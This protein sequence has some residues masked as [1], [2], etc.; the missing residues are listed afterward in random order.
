MRKVPLVVADKDDF[1]APTE[2]N[3]VELRMGSVIF[4][5]QAAATAAS[6]KAAVAAAAAAVA[7]VGQ[8]GEY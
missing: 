5:A 8:R 7:P 3:Q 6:G 2:I 1:V 4:F